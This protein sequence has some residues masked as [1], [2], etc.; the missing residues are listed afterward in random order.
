MRLPPGLLLANLRRARKGAGAGPSGLT[1]ECCR[2]VLDDER[3]SQLFVKAAQALARA[4]VTPAVA[5]AC[6]LGRVVAL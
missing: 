2:V 5:A 4:Q 1:A 6:G 3:A